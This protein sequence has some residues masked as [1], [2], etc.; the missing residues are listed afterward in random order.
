MATGIVTGMRRPPKGFH[1]PATVLVSLFILISLHALFTVLTDTYPAAKQLRPVQAQSELRHIVDS[2]IRLVEGPDCHILVTPQLDKPRQLLLN[3][4]L[5]EKGLKVHSIQ[6]QD[7]WP[8]FAGYGL[9]FLF[10]FL[11]L[12]Y[13]AIWCEGEWTE[14]QRDTISTD[15]VMVMASVFGSYGLAATLGWVWLTPWPFWMM[16]L[17]LCLA[18]RCK[19]F[20]PLQAGSKKPSWIWVGGK[21][22]KVNPLIRKMFEKRTDPEPQDDDGKVSIGDALECIRSGKP[23][24]FVPLVPE[25]ARELTEKERAERAVL[26]KTRNSTQ[27]SA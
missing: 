25:K 1:P 16:A 10:G 19:Y 5:T 24:G 8:E 6:V 26:L 27:E 4:I 13:F 3:T 12:T 17:A 22:L 18:P 14:E 21:K 23:K 11:C 9:W 2:R 7:D 15:R 20:V